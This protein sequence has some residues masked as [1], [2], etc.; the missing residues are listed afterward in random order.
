MNPNDDKEALGSQFDPRE[1]WEMRLEKNRGLHGVGYYGCGTQFNKISYRVKKHVFKRIITHLRMN[2][3]SANILDVGSGT[4]FYVEQW[5]RMHVQRLVGIDITRTSV[6]YLRR[7][8]PEYCFCE[9]DIGEN[10]ARIP[11]QSFDGISSLDVLFHITDDE[12]Y[13]QAFQN[14]YALLK[15]GGFFVFSEGMP[16]LRSQRAEHVVWRSRAHVEEIIKKT[17]FRVICNKPMHVLMNAPIG[18]HR[19]R[20]NHIWKVVYNITFRSKLAGM[21]LGLV[22][23]P[24]ELALVS[25]LKT[26]PTTE[27]VLCRKPR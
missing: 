23:Y 22:L 1:Y 24:I 2:M 19:S 11:N 5:K 10:I 14:V 26:S 18:S 4:G 12:K 25:L 27:I 17:G 8:Y 20:I 3:A 15:P 7:K 21:S 13:R 9:L 6:N 16:S